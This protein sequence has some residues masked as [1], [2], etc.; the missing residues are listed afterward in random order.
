[1][2]DD[3]YGQD[4][5]VALPGHEEELQ[6]R[7]GQTW[8]LHTALMP[9][10][11]CLTPG[12]F[13]S[14]PKGSRPALCVEHTDKSN[15]RLAAEAPEALGADDLRVLQVLVALGTSVGTPTQ[16]GQSDDPVQVDLGIA[17]NEGMDMGLLTRTT[18]RQIARETGQTSRGGRNDRAIRDSLDRLASVV[19]TESDADGEVVYD[20]LLLSRQ[21]HGNGE[22]SFCLSPYMTWSCYQVRR[23][24]VLPLHQ[25]RGLES[26]RAGILHHRLCGWLDPGEVRTIKLDTLATYIHP[27]INEQPKDLQRKLRYRTKIDLASLEL[28]FWSCTAQEDGLFKIH[29]PDL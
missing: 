16:P 21:Y 8:H 23:Y 20:G 4:S 2:D 5:V 11:L 3:F 12:L 26:R 29:R 14:L 10:G 25:S 17:I 15:H 9:P 19:L 6:Q 27:D 7:R 18:M 13:R 28:M 24:V 1:M 22:V